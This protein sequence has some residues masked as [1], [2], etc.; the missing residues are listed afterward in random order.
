[1]ALAILL[2]SS[3]GYLGLGAQPPTAEWGVLIADGKN[4]MTTGLVDVGLPRHRHRARRRR[5]QPGRRRPRRY[6]PAA[7]MMRPRRQLPA[8]RCSRCATCAS[9]SAPPRHE[10]AAV[11]GVDFDVAPGEVLGLV[12]ESGSGKSVTLRSILRLVKPPGTCQRP[13]PLARPRSPAH[14]RAGAA[15]ACAAARSR[16]IFQ[17][18]MTALNPVLTVGMQIGE[19]LEEHTDLDGAARAGARDRAARPWS[20][21]RRPSAHRGLSAPVLRRH[22]PARDDRHRARLRARSCC[23]PTSRPPRSTSPSRTRS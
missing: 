19:N 4:F 2:G 13:G 10:L 18:P 15:R 9:P 16:M 22:A 8:S 7:P 14:A 23:W 6:V 12:G 20:A 1:M 21:F 5:L 17:E 11:D 3:L